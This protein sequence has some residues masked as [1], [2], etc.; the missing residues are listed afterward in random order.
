MNAKKWSQRLQKWRGGGPIE[1]D[2][3]LYRV[4]LDEI[5]RLGESRTGE[6]DS[7]LRQI[8]DSLR[9]RAQKKSRTG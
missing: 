1:E 3:T 8:A 7:R 4:A 9:A 6:P 5:N 2:L